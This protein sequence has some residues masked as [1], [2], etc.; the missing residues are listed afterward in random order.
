MAKPSALTISPTF[1]KV[2]WR[3]IPLLLLL[4]VFNSLDRINIGFAALT[5]NVDIGLSAAAYGLGAGLFFVG[6]FL[7]EIPSNLIMNRVGARIWITRIAITWG[8]I[9]SL[10]FLIVSPGTFYLARVM[11]GVAEAGF[12]PAVTLYLLRWSPA[13]LRA[14]V[15][16]IY[17][18][19]VPIANSIGAILSSWLIGH[20]LFGLTGWRTMFL[21]EG[22]PTIVLGLLTLFLLP[23][24]PRT[25]KFLTPAEKEEIAEMLAEDGPTT[26]VHTSWRD[27]IR[28]AGRALKRPRII[29]LALCFVSFSVATFGV[30]YFLPLM[31]RGFSELAGHQFTVM[32]TG[33]WTAIPY[34]VVAC[35]MLVYSRVV[36]RAA[37]PSGW[38]VSV[39]L[40]IG[41]IAITSASAFTSPYVLLI[42]V[43]VGLSTS[44]GLGPVFWKT[45]APLIG[46][47]DSRQ[48]AGIAGAAAAASVALINATGNLGG[49]VG[50]YTIGWISDSTGS[51]KGGLIVVGLVMVVAACVLALIYRN[52]YRRVYGPAATDPTRPDNDQRDVA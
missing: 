19:S 11:L 15:T 25:A 20:P 50:P 5:M 43:A 18:V 26:E 36:D 16:S 47:S 3:I 49:F 38:H 44:L 33:L 10:H 17:Y 21:I 32:E 41:A 6:Y 51:Y 24:S 40:I 34:A 35:F 13:R 52:Y 2:L 22:L 12:F 4:Q 1:R 46:T 28:E 23:D 30:G 27:D 7:F 9:S 48:S 8:L 39:P 31:L 45:S 37:R 14:S 42:L 29:G